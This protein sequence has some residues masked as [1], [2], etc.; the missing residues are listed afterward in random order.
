MGL[1]LNRLSDLGLNAFFAL[2]LHQQLLQVL[3]LGKRRDRG[4][5]R[6]AVSNGAVKGY[7][8]EPGPWQSMGVHGLHMGL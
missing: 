8:R 1:L 5:E 4:R 7:W 2:S 3:E 6:A